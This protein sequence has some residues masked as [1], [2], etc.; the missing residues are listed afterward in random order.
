MTNKLRAQLSFSGWFSIYD[1]KHLPPMDGTR[2]L[3]HSPKTHTYTA[4]CGF[5]D[6]ID[7]QW[8]EWDS[9]YPCDPTHWAPLPPAPLSKSESDNIIEGFS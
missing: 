4:I 1:S 3:L 5:W 8:E 9:N 2:V 7:G 6:I